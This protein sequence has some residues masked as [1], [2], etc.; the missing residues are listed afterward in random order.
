M[1]EGEVLKRKLAII[2]GIIIIVVLIIGGKS[3]MDEKKLNEEMIEVVYS[4]EA[5]RV[6]E[7]K[8]RE[9]DSKA[10][11]KD[12][13]INSYEIDKTSIKHNPMGGIDVD[14]VVNGDKG[15]SIDFNLDKGNKGHLKS[16]GLGIS[17]ELSKKLGRWEEYK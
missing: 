5:K 12:G 2:V 7:D 15:L 1:K 14:I 8:L 11:T 9:L 17:G 13:I 6:F 16:G 10:L 4:E 3:Y